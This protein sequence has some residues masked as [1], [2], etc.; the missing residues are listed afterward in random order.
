ME[1]D[2]GQLTVENKMDIVRWFLSGYSFPEIVHNALEH[3]NFI[4][5]HEAL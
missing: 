1:E 5:G 4:L 3:N 2:G